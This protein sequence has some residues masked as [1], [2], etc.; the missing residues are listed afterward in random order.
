M[1]ALTANAEQPANPE[2]P[3]PSRGEENPVPSLFD[4]TVAAPT[5]PNAA[6]GAPG[7]GRG[8]VSLA[9]TLRLDL[10]RGR[11]ILLW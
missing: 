2:W 3:C 4:A 11:T 1:G 6:Q 8:G 7:S 10:A 9:V 5:P